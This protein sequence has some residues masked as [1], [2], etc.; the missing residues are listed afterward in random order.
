MPYVLF[1]RRFCADSDGAMGVIMAA[2]LGVSLVLCALAVDA[3]SLYLE[4]RTAQGAADLAAIAAARDLPR[5][6]AAARAALRAN[7]VRS[8]DRLSVVKGHYAADPTLPSGA[9]FKA[10]AEPHNAVRVDLAFAGR[11]HFAGAFARRPE[12]AVSAIGAAD[13]QAMFSIGSRLASVRG[14]LANAILGGLLGGSISLSVMDYTALVQGHI[15]LAGFLSALAA[16]VGVTAGTYDQLLDSKVTIGH[17]LS[18]AAEVSRASGQGQAAYA[19]AALAAQAN[20]SQRIPLRSIVDLGPFAR[21]GVGEALS[22]LNADVNV[23]SLITASATAANGARQVSVDLGVAVPG[24]LGLTL[25]VAIGER[26]HDSG[27]VAVG[28]AGARLYTAQTRLRLVADV[29]GS[30]LLAGVR[31]RLP[32]YIELAS[33][34]AQLDALNCRGGNGQGEAVI[35]ARPAAVRAWIGEVNP[36]GLSMFGTSVPVLAAK[37]VQTPL[38]SISA[39]A[40][41]EIANMQPVPLTFT[42]ADVE[43]RRVKTA[44]V[45]DYLTSLVSRLLQT[46]DIRVSLLGLGSL[47]A[48]KGALLGI[49]TPVAATLDGVLAPLLELLGVHIG[50]VDVR[51]HGFTCGRAVLAG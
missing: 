42:Q 14:G 5:A 8:L 28:Q 1:F 25:E 9:R 23:L 12:I 34:E 19:L 30:G 33:A 13:A 7:G 6:E 39:Q 17:V 37:L 20:A 2:V 36:A 31:I 51:V 21:L 38:L 48:V 10:G 35:L 32:I 26:A 11:L 43:A 15:S 44:D 50:E 18:A 3:G 24:L 49:L 47:V 22:A 46:A 16:E 40:Y 27:W 29:G 41:G 45:S 4:R